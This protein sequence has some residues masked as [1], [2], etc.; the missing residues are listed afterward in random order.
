MLK[1]SKIISSE[2]QSIAKDNSAYLRIL[3]MLKWKI[4]YLFDQTCVEMAKLLQYSKLIN[5]TCVELTKALRYSW[6]HKSNVI[7]S[8]PVSKMWHG[9]I[10]VATEFQKAHERSGLGLEV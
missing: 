5:E 4:N 8:S 9:I 6:Q 10:I 7:Q 3:H 1:F 2:S